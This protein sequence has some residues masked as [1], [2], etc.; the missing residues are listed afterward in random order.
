[1]RRAIIV[2]AIAVLSIFP[3]CSKY[4]LVGPPEFNVEIQFKCEQ[5]ITPGESVTTY[6][7]TALTINGHPIELTQSVSS[8]ESRFEVE[9]K[10]YGTIQFRV[11]GSGMTSFLSLYLTKEQQESIRALGQPTGEI[12]SIAVLPLVDLSGDPEQEP[13][14]DRM[15]ETLI[16]RLADTGIGAFDKGAPFTSVMMLKGSYDLFNIARERV[17]DAVPLGRVRRMESRVRPAV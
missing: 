16:S 3:G 17:V 11:E 6:T 14:A 5:T 8:S 12:C 7:V 15:T 4:K 2:I 9:T 13:F 10:R 1:M